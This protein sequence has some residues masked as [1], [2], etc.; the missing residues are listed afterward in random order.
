MEGSPL[1]EKKKKKRNKKEHNYRSMHV[2][3][4]SLPEF[5]TL[6]IERKIAL[7]PGFPTTVWCLVTYTAKMKGEVLEAFIIQYLM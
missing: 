4:Q 3:F 1:I 7:F 2:T 6:Q 5:N